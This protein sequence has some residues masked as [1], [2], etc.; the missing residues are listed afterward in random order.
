METLALMIQ[1]M[2]V[3]LYSVKQEFSVQE[4]LMSNQFKSLHCALKI[5]LT[6]AEKEQRQNA[7]LLK[8]LTTLQ[9][10]MA[11]KNKELSNKNAV[12][13]QLQSYIEQNKV[14]EVNKALK[15]RVGIKSRVVGTGL[16]VAGYIRKTFSLN[17]QSTS[18]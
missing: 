9:R 12:I 6:N 15:S 5:Y 11:E 4:E 7:E 18:K 8:N 13:Y 2:K 16:K 1:Q 14:G 17:K 3:K 10:D